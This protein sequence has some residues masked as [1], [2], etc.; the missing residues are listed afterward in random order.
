ME[1]KQVIEHP[2]SDSEI[3]EFIP[4]L[5]II[6]YSDLDKYHSI[7]ELLTP[8]KPS[9]MLLYETEPNSGHWTCLMKYGNTVEYFDSYGRHPD[10]PLEWGQDNERLGQGH[11]HLTELLQRAKSNVVWNKTPF[12]KDKAGI[13]DCGRHC[14]L[15]LKMLKKGLNLPDYTKFLKECREEWN[16]DYDTAVSGL[17][18]ELR[19]RV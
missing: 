6:T 5:P 15:R 18:S 14:I 13:N 17:I 19:E 11:K 9:C 4:G 2:L 16:C 12:Q 10:E 3:N 1:L 8:F 7:H